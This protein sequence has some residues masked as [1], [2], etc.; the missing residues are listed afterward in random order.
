MGV[1][2]PD[3]NS[4]SGES[5]GKLLDIIADIDENLRIL[6]GKNLPLECEQLI[7]YIESRVMALRSKLI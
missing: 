3:I 4:A 2:S 6:A 1:H 5:K 7:A